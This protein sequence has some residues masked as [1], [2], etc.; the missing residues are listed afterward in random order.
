[1]PAKTP[2]TSALTDGGGRWGDR[3][4]R[5]IAIGSGG[6][7][8]AAI[9]LMGLFLFIRAMPSLSANNVNFFTSTEFN[10]TDS[11]NLRFGIAE[12][13][14]VTVLSSVFALV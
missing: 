2:Q 14:Q 9:A 6:V 8:I 4:F 5:S 3:I 12:L 13:F 7:I 11:D 10:T 1:M